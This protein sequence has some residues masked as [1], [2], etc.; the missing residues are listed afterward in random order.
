MGHNLNGQNSR[1]WRRQRKP[2]N[3]L[4]FMQRLG[5]PQW[6]Y[7]RAVAQGVPRA[8]A[9]KRYLAIH[10]A[11]E[12]I[13]AHRLVVGAAQGVA[14]RHGD[15][16]WRLIGMDI[17]DRPGEAP[18]APSLEEW[19]DAEGLDG[20]SEAELQDLY[21]ERFG[22]G[23]PR[24]ARRRARNVRLCK[25]RLEL[26]VNLQSQAQTPP[27]IHDLL[28]GWLPAALVRRLVNS[29]DV[30]LGDLQRR[31][32]A[33]GRWYAFLPAYGPV[34]ARHL[35]DYL[36]LLL[37]A[38]PAS[39]A[40][41]LQA[42]GEE[43]SRLSGQQGSN[44]LRLA[45]GAAQ[46]I[47]ADNDRSAIRAWIA[48]RAGSALTAKQYEREAER[49]VL[50]CILE[51]SKALSDATA[52][53]CRAYMDFLADVPAH[54]VDG[55]GPPRLSAQWR[56]FA[57]PLSVASQQL[58]LTILNALFSWLAQARYLASNP[59]VL[60]NRKLGDDQ[61]QE[62]DIT[63]R[64]FTPAAWAAMLA[65]LQGAGDTPATQR[66]RWLCTFVEATGLRAAELIQAQRE[67]LKPTAKGWL[68]RVHG[69]GRRNRTVP[70][71]SVA[72]VATRAYFAHRG[73]EFDEAP[74]AT[75]LLGS[76]LDPAQGIRYAALYE[77]FTRFVKRVA[78]AVPPSQRQQLARGSMHWLRHTHA[79]R[80]AERGV[81]A[82]ILQE[83]L[84]QSDPR[85]TA[86]YFRAQ[87]QR[88]QAA[89][90]QAF[91]QTSEPFPSG[92]A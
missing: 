57:K 81:P 33:G 68:L 52:E 77:T 4:T 92:N 66:L 3:S 16:R 37:G 45:P 90:E 25:R 30:T 18:S 17:P 48:A 26:I 7:L 14:R 76:T 22:V 91:G 46:G 82:D 5:P 29:G 63:S 75:P 74:P 83:N 61:A 59:W 41:S 42:R 9:A 47:E 12:A 50:W 21:A 27:S 2:L 62:D 84:G 36:Q 13:T 64:A 78:K 80:A 56:P 89:M 39:P 15:S 34:K 86:R 73:L 55:G 60:V 1:C 24:D 88:R 72:I 40:F 65:Q 11:A 28:E 67:H 49:F 35:S 19:A 53:D 87:I 51:R 10:H 85:T 79:T 31:I 32:S 70:V 54:W 23:D 69:K 38:T 20:W 44:R 58:A 43:A 8:D 6:A 71:A